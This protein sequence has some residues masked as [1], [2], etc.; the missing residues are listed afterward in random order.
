[1]RDYS[2]LFRA[3]ESTH[4][5]P[6]LNTLSDQLDAAWKNPSHGNFGKWMQAVQQLPQITPSMVDLRSPVVQVGDVQDCDDL[7]R[8]KIEHNLRQLHPWRKGPFSILGIPIDTEWR[9]DWKWDRF[10]EHIKPLRGRKVLDV[11]CGNGYHCWRMAGE[12]A[13]LVLGIDPTLL[14]VMQYQAIRHFLINKPVHVLP[15]GIDDIPENLQA[16]DSVFSMGVLYHRKS[17]KEHLCKLFGCLCDGG[18]LILETLVIEGSAGEVLTPKGR[19][20]QMRNVWNIPSCATVENWLQECNYT[21]VR[22]IG[23]T[24][25][26]I[27]EQ[28]STAWMQFHSLRDFLDPNDS[29]RTVEGLPAPTRAIFLANRR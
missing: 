21:H 28:R 26:T 17:P 14:Y 4:L 15:L 24:R 13:N 10:I 27:E 8:E 1:M 2:S 16:F 25:T 20:A 7:T 5:A 9:S 23:K 6:W 3:M 19:Y 29:T 11:G 18:E 22:M 12:G